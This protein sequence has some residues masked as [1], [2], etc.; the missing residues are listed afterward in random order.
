MSRSAYVLTDDARDDMYFIWLHVAEIDGEARADRLLSKFEAAI[1]R[2]AG[3]PRIG[4]LRPEFGFA[5]ARYW[6]AEGFVIAYGPEEK[7]L[8]VYR[9]IHGSRNLGALFRPAKPE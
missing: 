5:G 8:T 6:A 1:R 4:R 3:R 2:L 7:P 9:V